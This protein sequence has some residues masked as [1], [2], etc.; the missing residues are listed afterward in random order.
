MRHDT[1]MAS[2]NNKI[3]FGY[4]ALDLALR[5]THTD[6]TTEEG[7]NDALSALGRFTEEGYALAEFAID[8]HP[9]RRPQVLDA[10][11]RAAR[12]TETDFANL[13]QA[14]AK[15]PTTL[16]LKKA[17]ERLATSLQP[18]LH[19]RSARGPPQFS[20]Q[21]LWPSLPDT[22]VRAAETN[23]APLELGRSPHQLT[24]DEYFY[25]AATIANTLDPNPAGA[26]FDALTHLFD[27]LAPPDTSSDGPYA[28]TPT[29]LHSESCIAG[30]IW[31][32][33]GDM[34][35]KSR[36]QAAHAVLLL[37]RLGCKDELDGVVRLKPDGA[38]PIAP[39]VDA[40]FALLLILHARMWLLLALARA[41]QEPNA[42]ILTGFMPWLISL[43]RGPRHAAIQVLA[44]RT[45]GVL[46]DRN[47]VALE[48]SADI[49]TTRLVADWVELEYQERRA[50]PNPLGFPGTGGGRFRTVPVLSRLP[51]VLVQRRAKPSKYRGGHRASRYPSGT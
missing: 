35:I 33:L 51:A 22:T 41:A 23:R 10:L 28:S 3:N 42:G 18:A 48:P 6:F 49:L 24:Y 4:V 2:T 13:A 47:L 16:G 27:D 9:N 5:F 17:L 40:R 8:K 50:R 38:D 15:R 14:A 21:K 39:F 45:L 12:A 7:W 36:W 44:Q 29:L 30:V 11:A 34:A 26:V 32:A 19:G 46:S 37:V 43:V 1:P 20:T 31:A 25:L